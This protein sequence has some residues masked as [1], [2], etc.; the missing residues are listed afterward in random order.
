MSDKDPD[1]QYKLRKAYWDERAASC[2]GVHKVLNV[3]NA[4]ELAG[5]EIEEFLAA[6]PSYDGKTV[7]D[8]G[9]GIG[10]YTAEFAKKAKHVTAVDFLEE[11]TEINKETNGMMGNIDFMTAD[12]VKAEFSPDSFDLIY[13]NYLMQYLTDD[14]ACKFAHNALRWMKEDG[15]LFFREL[16]GTPLQGPEE[17]VDNPSIC[18]SVAVYKEMFSNIC[19]P[20]DG[21]D[22][23]LKLSLYDS[24]QVQCVKKVL[25][26]ETD[27]YFIY[28]KIR[29]KR[30]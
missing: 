21:S 3:T 5:L 11:Y 29:C 1:K 2:D 28:Q 16:S 24:K 15:Y 6:L 13:T 12:I 19:Q 25:G 14:E 8:I 27:F 17:A 20:I 4:E 26:R 10:R 30:D 22:E 18:R 23:M 9:A 7:C